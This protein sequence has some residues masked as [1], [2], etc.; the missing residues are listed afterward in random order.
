MTHTGKNRVRVCSI[1]KA[2][3]AL[4]FPEH[5]A[6]AATM[7]SRRD[8]GTL[9]AGGIWTWPC[10]YSTHTLALMHADEASNDAFGMHRYKHSK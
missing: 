7:A 3:A 5:S 2:N 8:F 10:E 4:L 9:R 1:Q 6:V